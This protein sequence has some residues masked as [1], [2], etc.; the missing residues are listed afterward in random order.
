MAGPVSMSLGPYA[1]EAH[2]FGYTDVT[3]NLDTSWASIEVVD[4][5]EAL[6]WTGPKSEGMSIRGVLFPHEFGG[7]ASLEGLRAAAI[8]G[9]PLMLVSLDGGIFGMQVI[10][11]ISEDRAFMDHLGRPRKNAWSIDLRRYEEAGSLAQ[12]SSQPGSQSTG[13]F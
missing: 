3:R 4:R 10:N 13:L 1:F 8:S 5:F 9:E 6:Q 7:D 12:S 11:G 2:G